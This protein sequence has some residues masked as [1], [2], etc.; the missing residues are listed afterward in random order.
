M[1]ICLDAGHY[2]KYNNSPAN[3]AYWESD[4]KF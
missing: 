3:Q 2:G 1:K 4:I